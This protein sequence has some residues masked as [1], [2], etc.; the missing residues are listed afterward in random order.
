M[1]VTAIYDKEYTA[2]SSTINS[3]LRAAARVNDGSRGS[4]ETAS[5]SS[6]ALSALNAQIAHNDKMSASSVT[7]TLNDGSGALTYISF[8]NSSGAV[9]WNGN[10]LNLKGFANTLKDDIVIKNG[11]NGLVDVYNLSTGQ[12]LTLNKDGT[13]QMK[14]GA[15]DPAAIQNGSFTAA[16]LSIGLFINNRG[17]AANT[18]NG[19]DII[20][21]RQA[22]ALV[23]AGQGDDKIFNFAATAVKLEGGGGNESVYSLALTTNTIIDVSGGNS[24]VKLYGNMT[25][26]DIR[27]GSGTNFVDAA[28][29]TLA[30]VSITD[31]PDSLAS[32]IVA[33]T[34]SSR[35]AITV[36]A[37]MAAVDVGLLSSSRIN[38]GSG[39]N[40]LV[41]DKITGKATDQ[42]SITSQGVNTYKIGATNFTHI[43]SSAAEADAIKIT[44][45]TADSR[46][47][48]SKG[49]NLLNAAGQTLTA[50]KITSKA[51]GAGATSILAGSIAGR[52]LLEGLSEINLAGNDGNSIEVAKTVKNAK[53]DTGEGASTFKAGGA[54]SL[55]LSMGGAGSHKDQ[56]VQINGA[57][58]KFNY[59][60]SGGND[61]LRILGGVNNS[62]IDLGA[63]DN[64]FTA[65]NAKGV[66]QAVSNTNIT[67]SGNGATSLVLGNYVY[68]ATG[69]SIELGAGANTVNMGAVAGKGIAGLRLD[70]GAS[71][72][73]QSVTIG[74]AANY[75]NYMGSQGDDALTVMGAVNNSSIDLGAGDNSLTARNAKGVAQTVSN[76]NITASGDGA[77][78]LA[79][80]TY[81]YSATGNSIEL[82]AGANS[83][84]LGA[85]S[86]KGTA[87]LRIDLS[88]SE[89]DQSVTLGSSVNYLTY[90]GSKGDDALTILGALNNSNIDLGE[91]DNSLTAQNAK[92]V[93]QAVGNTNIAASGAGASIIT[94]GAYK[95]GTAGNA[96]TLG[97]GANTVNFASI[98]GNGA[99]GLELAMASTANDQTLNV[100]GAVSRLVYS[101]SSGND[102]INIGGSVLNS[103]FELGEGDNSFIAAAARSSVTDTLINAG[104]N[105]ANAV[106]ILTFASTAKGNGS[107]T[108]GAGDDVVTIGTLKGNTRVDT[109]LGDN[110]AFTATTVD[111]AAVT[112]LGAGAYTVTT[113]KNAHFD[114]SASTRDIR[115]DILTSLVN[116][117]VDLGAGDTRIG[118]SEDKARPDI[119]NSKINSGTGNLTLDIRN[120]TSSTI[121]MDASDADNPALLD[122]TMS[123]AMNK[124]YVELGHGANTITAGTIA[125][126]AITR[127]EK[128]G[129]TLNS[130]NVSS[131][132]FDLSG[133][134]SDTLNINGNPKA[135]I[136][137]GG[138]ADS[139]A[140]SGAMSGQL[141]SEA[142]L[143]LTSESL[144]KLSAGLAG[145]N[146][147][148]NIGRTIEGSTLTLGA[149]SNIISHGEGEDNNLNIASS[150]I[151]SGGEL[152]IDARNLAS[153]QITSAAYG[154]EEARLDLQLNKMTGSTVDLS[155]ADNKL[156]VTESLADSTLNLGDG[157]AVVGADSA[158]YS[159]VKITGGHADYSIRG[160][161]YEG[162][163]IA[164]GDGNNSIGL[165]ESIAAKVTL[166]GGVNSIGTATTSLRKFSFFGVGS[167]T[168]QGKDLVGGS[169]SL[170]AQG[171]VNQL[172]VSGLVEDSEIA[173]NGGDNTVGGA[174]AVLKNSKIHGTAAGD[175]AITAQSMRGGSVILGASNDRVD[176]FGNIE[177]AA[178]DLG[179]GL[180]TLRNTLAAGEDPAQ[181]GQGS[182]T[183]NTV[184]NSNIALSGHTNVYL[185]HLKSGARLFGTGA[186]NIN[187]ATVEDSAIDASG[188]TG[189]YLGVGTLKGSVGE[190]G[191]NSGTI[192]AGSGGRIEI[193]KMDG[194]DISDQKGQNAIIVGDMGETAGIN[195]GESIY[196]TSIHVNKLGGAL[197][198]GNRNYADSGAD[199]FTVADAAYPGTVKIEGTRV[200]GA[201]TVVSAVDTGN[202]GLGEGS[203]VA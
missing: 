138:G 160:A 112:G 31:D 48:L 82:G 171:K 187:A 146:N 79:L 123:G 22:D 88:A 157:K 169:V 69:N 53:I 136:Y 192:T 183:G 71:Q 80:G 102:S 83:I 78:S 190:D 161:R 41:A 145:E 142:D 168:I 122:L 153:S 77:A 92:G 179:A 3:R 109:G 15:P 51:G 125:Q 198:L 177:N 203:L 21:N 141:K 143:T 188:M 47:D 148:L 106:N 162:G 68:S 185:G 139:I 23:N 135:E 81:V 70:L 6:E 137:L 42:S 111:G 54:D 55:T 38:F 74:G 58:N 126:S 113:A 85:V 75:L 39:A 196:S 46:F 132:Q 8:S 127:L 2:P 156:N 29:Y 76:T 7:T 36:H 200:D 96:I 140:V 103:H 34:I 94:A 178:I 172:L 93:L 99:K 14:D 90:T 27:L 98:A 9:A 184:S 115:L 194:G 13:R 159:N 64:S 61:D 43:D 35:S 66:A 167:N 63:G 12:R 33:R 59:A 201:G 149:G 117:K 191:K 110:D 87:G 155:G 180:N 40:S 84:S 17:E 130:G 45:A 28:G 114:F 37:A 89:L 154:E 108:L 57:V 62:D 97:E 32:A 86:G 147:R 202:F 49:N 193:N 24:Y 30:G 174:D 131:G 129:L 95:A 107:I 100:S 197:N 166:G 133:E 181:A 116:S 56:T 5:F 105:G 26:G 151:K 18:G 134:G 195:I 170:G 104:G 1:E 164:L 189:A 25:G 16:D 120:L 91:G 67:A 73:S 50:V 152:K 176:I 128:G 19:N 121:K 10:T 144:S 199:K 150:T 165:T 163:S 20:I 182:A 124:S 118:S 44:G 65:Q 4:G 60:G 186:N 72:L 173:L 175:N 52:N 158:N 101:G 11:S 119:S